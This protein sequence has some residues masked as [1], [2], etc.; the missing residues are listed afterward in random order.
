MVLVVFVWKSL[1]YALTFKSIGVVFF[2]LTFPNYFSTRNASW[3]ASS[4][5]IN[6]AI[7]IFLY[8][9]HNLL[10]YPANVWWSVST[11]RLWTSIHGSGM[12]NCP[13]LR[14]LASAVTF[15]KTSSVH[16]QWASI[17]PSVVLSSLK[18]MDAGYTLAVLPH[19]PTRFVH[20]PSISF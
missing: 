13:L 11:I 7:N 9:S 15:F 14:T 3:Y 20:A 19:F 5:S 4:T 12:C 10:W 1:S 6:R 17:F 16:N 2:P 8:G 18:L